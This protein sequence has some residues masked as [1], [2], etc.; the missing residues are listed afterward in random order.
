MTVRQT[1]VQRG[2]FEAQTLRLISDAQVRDVLGPAVPTERA[3]R[4]KL[5]LSED[6]TT[7]RPSLVPGLLATAALN[8]RQGEAR[9]RFFELGRVFLTNPNG[10][11]REEERLA[12]LISGPTQAGSWHAKEPAPADVYD[13]RGA[14]EALPGLAG[15]ALELIPKPLEGWLLSAEIK[16]GGKTLGWVAQVHPARTRPM[17]ARHPVYVAELALNALQ[18]GQQGAA[19]FAG[20]PRFP[21]VTRDVAL[22]IPA[23]LPHAKVAAFFTSRKEPLLVG[24]EL[25]D[26]FADPTGGK[27]PVGKKS[28]AWTLTYRSAERTLETKEVDEAHSRILNSLIGSLPATIR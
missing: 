10:T 19:K 26:V 9:L 12:L 1:L 5:P 23:E 3:L 11:S 13:L 16:R 28:V 18:Q 4:V 14:L 21:S 24:A 22:E 27:I 25:F 20:L 15:Q 8:I 17:D 6:H 2:W 7:L